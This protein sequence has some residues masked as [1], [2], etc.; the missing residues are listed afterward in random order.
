[1]MKKKKRGEREKKKAS[2][3]AYK[4]ALSTKANEKARLK[5]LS[6]IL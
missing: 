3:Q 4:N 1:M 5:F 2:H 6:K